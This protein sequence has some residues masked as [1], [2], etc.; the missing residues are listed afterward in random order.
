MKKGFLMLIGAMMISAVGAQ[1]LTEG[2]MALVYFTPKNNVLLDFD[3]TVDVYEA[4]IYHKYAEEMLGISEAISETRT[5]Y[6]LTKVK[7]GRNTLADSNRPHKVVPD[8]VFPAQ[9]LSIDS[10]GLLMGYNLPI[11]KEKE[12]QHKPKADRPKQKSADD[13]F[14]FLPLT[15]EQLEIRG[16]EARAKAVAKQIYRIRETRMFILGGEVENPPA[17]GQA[18]R[19]VLKELDEQEKELVALFIGR[20][21]S[22]KE[23]KQ[24]VHQPIENAAEERFCLYF[25]DENGFTSPENIDA[26]SIIVT[27]KVNR[28][29]A[30]PA[31]VSKKQDKN[32]PVPSQ[33][34]YNLPGS[35]DI[36]VVYKEATL[37]EKNIPVAQY[38]ID[39]PLSRELFTGDKL[40]VIRFDTRTGNIRSIQQ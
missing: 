13:A 31:V 24:I 38:G 21:S 26:D 11:E 2:E 39:V 33:L 20:H 8:K 19:L 9:L 18:M 34:V 16:E 7:I 12:E 15:D 6:Q 5:E 1:Q 3:Y 29:S 35:V 30:Q 32:A 27:L 40:P 36:T 10:R 4:G 23:H 25:S 17:D 28:Q 14:Q 37:A 22:H